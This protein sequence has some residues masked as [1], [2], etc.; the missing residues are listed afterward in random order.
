MP[1]VTESWAYAN[2]NLSG[3]GWNA[4]VHDAGDPWQVVNNGIENTANVEMANNANTTIFAPWGWNGDWDLTFTLN[5]RNASAQ[6]KRSLNIAFMSDNAVAPCFAIWPNDSGPTA[7][8]DFSSAGQTTLLAQ[9]P[10][11]LA[12][13]FAVLLSKRGN[14]VTCY[15]N[16][17]FVFINNNGA[18][19]TSMGSGVVG[20]Q[21]YTPASGRIEMGTQTAGTDPVNNSILRISSIVFAS[22]FT[23]RRGPVSGIL[24][25]SLVA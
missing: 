18:P 13:D 10:F 16:G 21:T 23:G 19:W 7:S 8:F 14:S 3:G 4:T 11:P 25:G 2:G 20:G 5:L 17:T 15:S 24:T 1:G 22:Y 9:G 12:S 6:S